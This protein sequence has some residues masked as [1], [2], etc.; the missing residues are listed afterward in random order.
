MRTKAN[1]IK[2]NLYVIELRDEII[3]RLI[4]THK[5]YDLSFELLSIY[6][7]DLESKF[8]LKDYIKSL[9]YEKL[10]NNLIDVNS[11]GEDCLFQEDINLIPL[12]DDNIKVGEIE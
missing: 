9:D 1:L 11:E 5:D 3:T 12:L 6:N 4:V 7:N 10:F 2:N 8:S